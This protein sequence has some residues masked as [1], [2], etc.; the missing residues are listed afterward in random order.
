MANQDWLSL[1]EIARLW[2]EEAGESAEALERDLEHWFE[3]FVA[4]APLPQPGSPGREGD[5][6]NLLMGYLGGR[7]LQRETLAV[8]C[9]ER[10][11][12]MPRFW[13]ADDPED[14]EIG[15]PDSPPPTDLPGD[16]ARLGP[17][18]GEFA[19]G[20]RSEA[21]GTPAGPAGMTAAWPDPLRLTADAAPADAVARILARV[22]ALPPLGG[23]FSGRKATRLAG[24]L[25]CGLALLAAGFVLG[26]GG[27]GSSKAG[28]DEASAPLVTSLR[29]ELA[30]ARRQ[31]ASLGAALE[32]SEKDVTR[33]SADLLAARQAPEM[34]QGTPRDVAAESS[35][36]RQIL[37]VEIARTQAALSKQDL[38][39]AS[40]RLARFES[41]ARA[42]KAEAAGLAGEL[43]EAQRLG[44]AALETAAAESESA[45]QELGL[46]VQAASAHAARL[47]REL[48]A[49][50]QRIADLA[51][52]AGA[53]RS[54]AGGLAEQLADARMTHR[55]TLDK[56]RSEAAARQRTL[57]A[58]LE[59]ITELEAAQRP[60]DPRLGRPAPV[61]AAATTRDPAA[62]VDGGAEQPV[63][64]RATRRAPSAGAEA[65]DVDSLVADPA[66]YD[67]RQVVVTGSLLRLLQHYRLQSKSGLRTLVVDV[68][69]LHRAQ[70][71]QLQHA[72]ADAG[73]IGSV[74]ARIS[75]KVE[76]GSA[77]AFR[78]VASDLRLVE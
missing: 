71:D 36:Q 14:A 63:A 28:R 3:D 16:A 43:A 74:R 70:Y 46:A 34:A 29:S 47:S 76:R 65:I 24:G 7:H 13:N 58:A 26:Q 4:R 32:A 50:Q 72:I 57:D 10:G 6:T 75:G 5:T 52:E 37:A 2:S 54:E 48:A 22:P 56:L 23:R 62:G 73:L 35:R 77:E 78:L 44:S 40:D 60:V 53:A 49:A 66:R 45:R 39:A 68:A 42:A 64:T 8:Y 12:E 61:S 20:A 31:I 17:A 51:A 21:S 41:E 1:T 9:V 59:R 19:A 27:T 55:A 38:A 67:A 18:A 15:D 69:G 30:E 33:L 11:R 25:A